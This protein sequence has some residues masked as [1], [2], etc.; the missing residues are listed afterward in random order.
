M[1]VLNLLS[2][3]NGLYLHAKKVLATYTTAEAEDYGCYVHNHVLYMYVHAYIYIEI[4][5]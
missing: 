1:Y 2:S 4:K 3:A 5:T